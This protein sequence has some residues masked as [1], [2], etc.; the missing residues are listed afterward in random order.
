MVYF[1]QLRRAAKQFSIKAYKAISHA[2]AVNYNNE[3]IINLIDVGAIGELPSPWFDN[4]RYIKNLLR[5]E[6]R[7]NAFSQPNIISLDF[8]LGSKNEE[9]PFHIYQGNYSHGSSFYESNYEFVNA[10]FDKLKSTGSPK[11]ARTWHERSKLLKT[12]NV[13]CKT[14]DIVLQDLNLDYSFDFLKIDAQGAEYEILS[15]SKIFLAEHCLGLQLELFTLPMYK[16]IKLKDEVI[17]YLSDRG[18]EL[19]KEFPPQGTF[20]C[21]NDCVFFKKDYPAQEERKMRFLRKIYKIN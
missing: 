1:K 15:G 16:N 19:I 6:P 18:F 10:N 4:A 21:V 9:R 13:Q 12:I 11:F 3:G 7:E 14:L 2:G 8:A 17:T 20:H 5:F